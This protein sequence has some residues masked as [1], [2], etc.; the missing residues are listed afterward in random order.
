MFSILCKNKLLS[1]IYIMVK[2]IK[3]KLNIDGVEIK[4]IRLKM[5]LCIRLRFESSLKLRNKCMS[6]VMQHN[7]NIVVEIE[8]AHLLASL[9]RSAH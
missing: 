9:Q 6:R 2:C 8:T 1:K 7:R 5:F 3:W 4:N